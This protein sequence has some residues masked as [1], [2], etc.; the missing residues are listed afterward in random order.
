MLFLLLLFGIVVVGMLEFLCFVEY[1]DI[2]GVYCLWI[3]IFM[4]SFNLC[5][6]FSIIFGFCLMKNFEIFRI[7]VV[8]Y[9]ERNVI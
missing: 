7:L 8:L 3:S 5:F 1:F 9:K 2:N 4:L 6:Y